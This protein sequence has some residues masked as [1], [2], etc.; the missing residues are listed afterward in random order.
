MK[1]WYLDNKEE[2]KAHMKDYYY[3]VK[4]PKLLEKKNDIEK[5]NILS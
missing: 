2:W 1:Q 3:N 4:K 5:K